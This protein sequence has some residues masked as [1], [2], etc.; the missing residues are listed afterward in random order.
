M[1][2][3]ENKARWGKRTADTLIDKCGWDG[4]NGSPKVERQSV[5]QSPQAS[6]ASVVAFSVTPQ[7]PP[8]SNW[9][10]LLEEGSVLTNLSPAAPYRTHRTP[11]LP[12]QLLGMSNATY[13]L[14][15]DPVNLLGFEMLH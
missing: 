6:R 10:I 13:L 5:F 11:L 7:R 4:A 8:R 1:R 9:V 2:S 15:A 14:V 3:Q 12:L